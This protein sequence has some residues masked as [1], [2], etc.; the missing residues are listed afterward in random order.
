[1]A[2]P[3]LAAPAQDAV[4]QLDAGRPPLSVRALGEAPLLDAEQ[5]LRVVP[6]EALQPD[7][8]QLL[9]AV[10]DEALQPDAEQL[11]CAVPDEAL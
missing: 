8:E 7:A 11:L 1:V 10:P 6:D 5:L 2:Q 9:L 4:P 3:Q